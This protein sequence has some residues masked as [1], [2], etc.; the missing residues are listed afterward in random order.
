MYI[1]KTKKQQWQHH[2]ILGYE[3]Y[4]LFCHTLSE[5]A[6]RQ[7]QFVIRR[8]KQY[9]LNMNAHMLLLVVFF[10]VLAYIRLFCGIVKAQEVNTPLWHLFS[11]IN[12]TEILQ[13]GTSFLQG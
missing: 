1:K 2:T 3:K 6:I 7:P 11:V 4:P 10:K 9:C 12:V 5:Q 8:T 13:P